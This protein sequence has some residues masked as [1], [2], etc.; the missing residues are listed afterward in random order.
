MR[1]SMDLL[2]VVKLVGSLI[3]ADT[4]IQRGVGRGVSQRR[5]GFV[6][7]KYKVEEDVGGKVLAFISVILR[8]IPPFLKHSF[9]SERHAGAQN[10]SPL[11]SVMSNN[12]N[13]TRQVN[14]EHV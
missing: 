11:S 4:G 9:E 10:L 12:T 1:R 5:S 8:G 14:I 7:R 3:F 2:F 13:N 6:F